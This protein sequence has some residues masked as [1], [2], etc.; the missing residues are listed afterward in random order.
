[1]CFVN[2]SKDIDWINFERIPNK[3]NL[4]MWTH[5]GVG[6]GGGEEGKHATF[7]GGLFFNSL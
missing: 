1:M 4:K 2:S 3:W 6:E 7:A 5:Y